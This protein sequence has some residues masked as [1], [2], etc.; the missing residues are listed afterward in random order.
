MSRTPLFPLVTRAIRQAHYANCM[1]VS[2]AETVARVQASRLRLREGAVEREWRGGLTR[3]DF[4]RGSTMAGAA[5]VLGGCARGGGVREVGEVGDAVLIVGAGLAGLVAARTLRSAGVRVRVVEAQNRVGGRVLSLRDHFADGQVAELG[6]ELIDTGHEVMRGLAAELEIEL[7]DLADEDA[8]VSTS[9]WYF[10][11]VVQSEAAVV[12]ALQPVARLAASAV[13][14]LSA[15][16]TYANPGSAVELDRVSI[17]EWLDRSGVSG[18]ARKLIDVAY[19]T[20]YG[21]EIDEQ[22]S[23]NLLFVLDPGGDPERIFGESD[24]RYHVRGG[25]DR[26][27]SR[28]AEGL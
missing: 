21:T 1:G 3:R 9:L 5:L 13:S 7:D 28:L 25:N 16:L 22:S 10:D 15:S 23:L 11:G 4:V 26:I 6:G 12:E 19:T 18:L 27:V 14:P 24:T 17:A 8:G 2:A 20:E